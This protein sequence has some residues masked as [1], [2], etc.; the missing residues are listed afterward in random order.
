MVSKHVTSYLT[1]LQPRDG[2][3]LLALECARPLWPWVTLE[4]L[5]EEATKLCPLLWGPSFWEPL[6]REPL[7]KKPGF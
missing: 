6:C 3:R 2:S 5:R 7:C 1:V 4:A